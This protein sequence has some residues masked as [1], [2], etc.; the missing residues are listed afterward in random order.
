[1]LKS[2]I[3]NG[4]HVD[5]NHINQYRPNTDF[6]RSTITFIQKWVEESKPFKVRTSGSTGTPKDII[7]Q[8]SQM[9]AS[10][11]ATN[12]F[13][14]LTPGDTVFL[15]LNT[16]YIAGQMMLV[17]AI[18]GQL[19][20]I[21]VEPNLTPQIDR[22]SSAIHF[23]AFVPMQIKNLLKKRSLDRNRELKGIIIGGAPVDGE[24]EDLL[25]TISI[26]AY[27][28][29]GMTE[30]VSH[31]ALR[32]LNGKTK[33]EYYQALPGIQL[34]SEKGC[35]TIKGAATNFEKIVTR[36]LVEFKD[37]KSFKWLGRKDNVVNSGGVKI[38]IEEV[39]KHLHQL[40]ETLDVS[41]RFI[42]SKKKDTQL[43][44]KLVLVL[45]GANHQFDQKSILSKL[46]ESLPKYWTPKEIVTLAKFP[47]TPTGKTDRREID[48]RLS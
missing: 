35:L 36:D 34:G 30:T 11:Q 32:E 12:T 33:S 48:R 29:F 42:C 9:M 7:I 19:N 15:C 17:R 31:I 3:L 47:E 37:S 1:M 22:S 45:E 13:F 41:T 20:V 40:L 5:I 26:P 14:K 38:Q 43:G 46:S 25:N 27:A 39:E 44:E 2:L 6:E 28:T 24:L 4:R 21:A 8:R 23:A 18:T 16:A 10:A